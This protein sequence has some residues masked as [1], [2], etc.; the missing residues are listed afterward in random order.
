MKK[1]NQTEI[2]DQK[3]AQLTQQHKLELMELKEQFQIVQNHLS[4]GNLVQEGFEGLY[5]SVTHK[6]NLMTTVLQI[7]GGYVS[8]K[9]VVGN[10]E[11]PKIGRAH[12]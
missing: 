4:P 11:N 8:K 6:K 2:L 5:K 10:S 12:V 9:V 1:R 3:I 7:L